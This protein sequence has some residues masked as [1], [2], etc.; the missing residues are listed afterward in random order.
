MGKGKGPSFTEIGP[1]VWLSVLSPA[2]LC[3]FRRDDVL[4][5]RKHGIKRGNDG[6]NVHTLNCTRRNGHATA[7]NV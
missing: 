3:W 1:R 5:I 2:V 7:R 4:N 6:V